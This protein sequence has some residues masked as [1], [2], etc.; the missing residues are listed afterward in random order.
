MI[1]KG[2]RRALPGPVHETTHVDWEKK[3][4]LTQAG[5]RS[6]YLAANLKEHTKRS[7]GL[8]AQNPAIFLHH[9]DYENTVPFRKMLSLAPHR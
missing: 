2:K 6:W 5:R 1:S 7:V 4:R 8:D 3:D 9:L